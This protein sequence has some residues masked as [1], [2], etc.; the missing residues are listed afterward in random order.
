MFEGGVRAGGEGGEHPCKVYSEC[1][2]SRAYTHATSCLK[3]IGRDD[4]A[5][6]H[7]LGDDVATGGVL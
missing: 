6:V 5:R 7:D 4:I 1:E 3:L 2:L